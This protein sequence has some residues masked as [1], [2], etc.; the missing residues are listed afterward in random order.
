MILDSQAFG[1]NVIGHESWHLED[2]FYSSQARRPDNLAPFKLETGITGA[3]LLQDALASLDC[4]VVS[5]HTAGDHTLFVGQVVDTRVRSAE[6]CLSSHDLPY[7]YL[8]GKILF[9]SSTRQ[10]LER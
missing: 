6:P 4:R 8:G 1:L 3:P 9:D 10:P 2:Y 7:I 5:T